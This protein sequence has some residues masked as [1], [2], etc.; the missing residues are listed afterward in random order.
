MSAR[1]KRRRAK[2]A[3]APKTEKLPSLPRLLDRKIYKTGQTRGADDDEIFQ[4]R[5]SR[6]GT[7][8]IPY[9][10]WDL[11]A[12]PPDAK[13]Q[14]ESGFIVLLSPDEYFGDVN[15]TA[16]LAAKG[17]EIGKNALVFY[18]TR[19][20]WIAHNPDDLNWKAAK[21][22]IK[23]L[24]GQYVAR[25]SAT[26]AAEN[27]KKIIRG[28]DVTKS[29]GAGIRVYE[30]SNNET[31]KNCRLQLEALFWLCSDSEKVAVS[32]GMSAEAA[33][34]RKAAILHKSKE[35]ELLDATQLIAARVLNSDGKTICPLCLEEL[36]G[37]GF[38]NRMEQAE[39]RLVHDL[40]ITQLNLFHIAELRY[41]VLNHRP[42]NLGWGHHHCNVVVKDAG[43]SATLE[44][45]RDLVNRNIT[46][47][48]L[49]AAKSGS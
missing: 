36:S 10:C 19:Q 3:K 32:N 18:E 34:T 48:H 6:S 30:Y 17:L 4:N 38:F 41:G 15:I 1:K 45:M 31:T 28:F 23:P 11:C 24:G 47:G 27:S 46:A 26:T 39:G 9:A 14:Y 2:S 7:V 49:P 8:L 29:K 5:V 35:L 43:I 42:Y 44:W 21:K 13:S 33:A 25:I 20:Q 22:R 37:Q 40:T 12:L 16:S